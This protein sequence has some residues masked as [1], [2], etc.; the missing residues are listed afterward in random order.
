MCE[1]CD[2]VWRGPE[3]SPCWL[4]NTPSDVHQV[5]I[6]QTSNLVPDATTDSEEFSTHRRVTG[7]GRVPA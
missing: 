2:V 1:E 4:C 5:L 6:I 7:R 3:G